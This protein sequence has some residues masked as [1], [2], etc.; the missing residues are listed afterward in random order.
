MSLWIESHQSLLTHRKTLRATAMLGVSKYQLI[1]H[2]HALWWWGLDNA[3]D[4]GDLGEI[5]PAEV[6][7]AAGWTG[8]ADAF[9]DALKVAGF[10]DYP[11]GGRLRLHDWWDYAGKLNSQRELRRQSNRDAQRRHRQRAGQQP[12]S[13]D[14]ADGQ[15]PTVPNLTNLTNLPPSGVA[16]ALRV[17]NG[18]VSEEPEASKPKRSRARPLER[19]EAELPRLKD[20]HPSLDVDRLFQE[21]QL[22]LKAKGR[23]YTDYV[24]AFEKWLLKEEDYGQERAQGPRGALAAFGNGHRE[25]SGGNRV[26]QA[27]LARRRVAAG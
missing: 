15:Q 12:V 9:V 5:W 19:V 16:P 18:H 17:E 14:G 23:T 26:S 27:E 8:D 4:D 2:L 13:A 20:E 7:E 10:L 11:D 21:F 22:Y 24:A 25:P 6:A 1:G 3:K